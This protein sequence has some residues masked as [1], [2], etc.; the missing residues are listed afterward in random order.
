MKEFLIVPV[1]NLAPRQ[2]VG[3]KRSRSES[4]DDASN[5]THEE[6]SWNHVIDSNAKTTTHSLKITEIMPQAVGWLGLVPPKQGR[7]A[8]FWLRGPLHFQ[9]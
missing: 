1:P 9:P 7:N 4:S 5:I 8:N 6:Q 3:V 2:G